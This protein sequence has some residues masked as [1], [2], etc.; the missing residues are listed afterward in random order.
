VSHRIRTWMVSALGIALA[1]I[2]LAVLL[3]AVSP[4]LAAR[5]PIRPAFLGGYA[6]IVVLGGSMEPT[7]HIGSILFIQ[8]VDPSA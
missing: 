2:V 5:H 4:L 6:P 3:V 7:Y 1:I 8:K